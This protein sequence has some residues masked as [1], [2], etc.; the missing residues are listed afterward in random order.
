MICGI[1]DMYRIWITVLGSHKFVINL[2]WQI[3]KNNL[4]TPW[5]EN[6]VFKPKWPWAW[7]DFISDIIT[8]I[9]YTVWIKTSYLKSS[10]WVRIQISSGHF[11]WNPRKI[12]SLRDQIKIS[13][14]TQS[15]LR[16]NVKERFVKIR[17]V[18]SGGEWHD[19]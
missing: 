11:K 4:Q 17:Q 13:W 1:S 2:M 5:Q 6:I 12:L 9:P 16:S 10:I 15:Q 7:I 8:D 19:N 14:L 18:P 3:E